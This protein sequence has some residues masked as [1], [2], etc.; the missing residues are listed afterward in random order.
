MELEELWRIGGEK[1]EHLFGLMIDARSDEKGNV[2]LLDHQ[3]SRVTMVSPQGQ[4]LRELGA[5]EMARGN[6]ALLKPSP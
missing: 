6:A 1:D 2:F 5:K 4:Y 3:L